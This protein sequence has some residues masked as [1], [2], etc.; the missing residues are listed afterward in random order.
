M[1]RLSRYVSPTDGYVRGLLLGGPAAGCL[2]FVMVLSAAAR[3]PEGQRLALW[4]ATTV[5]MT[6]ALW[7]LRPG[8]P[9]PSFRATLRRRYAVAVGLSAVVW[10]AV[11]VV[12]GGPATAGA[13]PVLSLWLSPMLVL[14][15][16]A[17]AVTER[18]D[19][20]PEDNAT[21]LR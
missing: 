2:F 7:T 11:F 3:V 8:H 4:A 17:W 14:L 19:R 10:P 9:A 12:V 20:R 13:M 15:G 18:L 1:R 21:E 16:S 6:A 5:A